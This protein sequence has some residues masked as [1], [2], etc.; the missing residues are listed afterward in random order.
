MMTLSRL[1]YLLRLARSKTGIVDQRWSNRLVWLRKKELIE[2]EPHS[3]R[4]ALVTI[5]SKGL[6]SARREVALYYSRAI[7]QYTKA[8]EEY[9]RRPSASRPSSVVV[10][11]GEAQ[12]HLK[13]IKELPW[14]SS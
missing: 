5:T 6:E 3:S 7:R 8:R 1:K 13:K 12:A 4:D 11:Y 2:L 9:R 10:R 14:I